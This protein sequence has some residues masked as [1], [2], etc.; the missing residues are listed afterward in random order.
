MSRAR[1]LSTCL[2][3]AMATV[4]PDAP[5]P[6]DMATSERLGRTGRRHLGKLP[7]AEHAQLLADWDAA[8]GYS[9]IHHTRAHLATMAPDRRA[10]LEGEWQ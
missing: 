9:A 3:H 5:H 2:Q 6:V 10:K 7:E 1:T 8:A 4:W